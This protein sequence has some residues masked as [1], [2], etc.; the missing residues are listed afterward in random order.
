MAAGKRKSTLGREKLITC[1][2]RAPASIFYVRVNEFLAYKIHKIKNN[3][4]LHFLIIKCFFLPFFSI[5][6]YVFNLRFLYEYTFE[7][8]ST[9]FNK[10]GTGQVKYLK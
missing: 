9:V 10:I 8:F 5:E 3:N 1:F 4:P 7:F 2:S 6:F